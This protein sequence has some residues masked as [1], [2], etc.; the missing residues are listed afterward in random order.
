[1]AAKRITP[2][3]LHAFLKKERADFPAHAKVFDQLMGEALVPFTDLLN[4]AAEAGVFD[5]KSA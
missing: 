4:R 2:D 1:M 3:E 5:R